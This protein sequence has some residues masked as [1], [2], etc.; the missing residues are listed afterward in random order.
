MSGR[1]DQWGVAIAF[2][3]PVLMAAFTLTAMWVEASGRSP[4][5]HF[6]EVAAACALFSVAGAM[7]GAILF[8]PQP[9]RVRGRVALA[10][11]AGAFGFCVY[12]TLT[13]CGA[14]LLQM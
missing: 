11:A 14:L 10:V 3:S 8:E 9:A 12:L 4:F 1:R 2:S 7:L 13:A 6:A 5:S